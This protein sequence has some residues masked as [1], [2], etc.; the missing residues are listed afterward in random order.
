MRAVVDLVLASAS[1]AGGLAGYLDYA[2]G[3]PRWHQPSGERRLVEIR[4][5]HLRS[6]AFAGP[7]DWLGRSMEHLASYPRVV[8]PGTFVFVLSDF[9]PVPASEVWLA[10]IERGWDLVPV[11]IQ[12]PVWEQSFPDVSG[13]VVPLRDPRSGRVRS[14]RLGRKDVA[15]RRA[16]NE[17]RLD[18]LLRGLRRLSLDPVLVSSSDPVEILSAH[19]AWSDTRRSRRVVGA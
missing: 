19:L 10:A 2:D 6:S 9:L 7:E 1:A 15:Q 3:T 11:V 17:A 16:L 18:E 12:D 4:E 8:T 5:D 13:I 14:V